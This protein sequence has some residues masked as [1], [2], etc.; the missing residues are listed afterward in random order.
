MP[1]TSP[2]TTSRAMV[3]KSLAGEIIYMVNAEH[4]HHAAA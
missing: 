4:V 3:L 2:T 1:P